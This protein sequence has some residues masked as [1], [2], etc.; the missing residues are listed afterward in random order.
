MGAAGWSSP[1]VQE[2]RKETWTVLFG[3]GPGFPRPP[4]MGWWWRRLPGQWGLGAPPEKGQ[5]PQALETTDHWAAETCDALRTR[6]LEGTLPHPHFQ[7]FQ[8]PGEAAVF[9]QHLAS[10]VYVSRVSQLCGARAAP[11]DSS[12]APYSACKFESPRQCGSQSRRTSVSETKRGTDPCPRPSPAKVGG[13][14]GLVVS[15]GSPRTPKK[16]HLDF[17]ACRPSPAHFFLPRSGP[18]LLSAPL[19]EVGW[20]AG[21]PEPP[22]DHQWAPACTARWKRESGAWRGWRAPGGRL[23]TSTPEP[24]R[25]AR[26]SSSGSLET[27]LGAPATMQRDGP[28]L[29]SQGSGA[30]AGDR[31]ARTARPPAWLPG[32]ALPHR[33]KRPFHAERGVHRCLGDKATAG[34]CDNLQLVSEGRGSCTKAPGPPEGRGQW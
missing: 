29:F 9:K 24:R 26:L 16:S 11:S 12:Q 3:T 33:G 2:S 31:E 6:W 7:L 21:E 20:L 25:P 14:P 28:T 27:A 19:G 5:S 8:P 15:A 1:R 34:A 22:W 13:A 23:P 30:H 32:T 10:N 18:G 17:H 4:S